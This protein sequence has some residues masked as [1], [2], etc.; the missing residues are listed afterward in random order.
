M[1]DS[2]RRTGVDDRRRA[3]DQRELIKQ[4]EQATQE[5][6]SAADVGSSALAL[7]ESILAR[8]RDQLG[9]TGGRVYRRDE[10]EFE[11]VATFGDARPVPR[12]FRVPADYEPI[13]RLEQRGVVFM[14]EGDPAVDPRLE[15]ELGTRGFAAIQV[16]EDTIL[17]FDV[18]EAVQPEEVRY[19]LGI[20]RHSITE[21]LRQER[22]HGILHE[23]RRIQASIT[24]RRS[25]EFPGYDIFGRTEPMEIV[26]GDYFDFIPVADKILG[27]AIADVS[28]HGL[29]AAL[30][31]RDI[32][33]GL[34]M[35]LSR[36]Y[37]IVRTVERMNAIIHESTLTNRFV[38]MFYGELEADGLLIYVNAGH[39]SPLHFRNDG[40]EVELEEGGPVLGPLR[41]ATYE[42]GF[43]RLRPGEMIVLYTDGIDEARRPLPGGKWE[44]YG[45]ERL[46]AVLRPHRER[47]AKE[48]VNAVCADIRA[49]RGTRPPRDDRTVVVVKREES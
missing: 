38:S 11:L 17:A 48:M 19:S 25:P 13:Q 42:R 36:D 1:S 35:G 7:A 6:E 41:D 22:L 23:A 27:L 29:P 15:Q 28:G 24:P 40:Q 10:D 2:D 32:Y 31:V 3:P 33:M 47:S 37:K 8:F 16:D 45:V 12:P 5:I 20:L 4:I 44:E 14:D 9:L 43:V 46:R 26:G 34:R 49:F 39:P 18:A 21:R 30:Q